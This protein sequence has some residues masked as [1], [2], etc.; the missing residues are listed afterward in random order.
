MGAAGTRVLPK[1]SVEVAF[2][3]HRPTCVAGGVQRPQ[4]QNLALH[5]PHFSLNFP[6]LLRLKW[7]W[8]GQSRVPT[9]TPFVRDRT[10]SNWLKNER[11]V[12]IH[13]TQRGKGS[14]LQVWL[15]SGAQVMQPGP[16]PALS[17]AS[18]HDGSTVG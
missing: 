16:P 6:R 1:A 7:G 8:E 5:G 10:I 12:L 17:S 11:D 3:K 2:P 15:D 18:L 4:P 14:Y 9:R 13:A